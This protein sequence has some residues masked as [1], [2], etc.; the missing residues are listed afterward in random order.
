LELEDGRDAL[1]REDSAAFAAGICELLASPGLRA[2][3][4]AAARAT[5][6]QRFTW[7]G[8]AENALATY[9]ALAATAVT[10]PRP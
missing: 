10:E 9:Q 4:S 5:V 1:I 3:L 6:E 8:I 2:S 7:Q